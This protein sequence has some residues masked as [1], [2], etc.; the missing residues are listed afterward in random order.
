MVKPP[1][2]LLSFR[3]VLDIMEFLFF[4]YEAE[5]VLSSSRKNCFRILMKI[6]LNL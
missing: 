5:I 3:I 1:V 2:V 4:P 6:A